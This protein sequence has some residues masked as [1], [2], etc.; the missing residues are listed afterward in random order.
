MNSESHPKTKKIM[1]AKVQSSP[2]NHTT[3]DLTESPFQAEKLNQV[4][5]VRIPHVLQTEDIQSHQAS[6][7]PSEL[8]KNQSKSSIKSSSDSIPLNPQSN[9][10]LTDK[11]ELI[12]FEINSNKQEIKNYKHNQDSFNQEISVIKK[13]IMKIELKLQDFNQKFEGLGPK[14]VKSFKNGKFSKEKSKTI[15]KQSQEFD[16][17][18]NQASQ[19]DLKTKRLVKV[20]LEMGKVSNDFV[21]IKNFIK[22]QVK[23]ISDEHV[24]FIESIN[25]LKRQIDSMVKRESLNAKSFNDKIAEVRNE[26]KEVKGPLA[27][28]ISDQTRESCSLAGEVRR[29]QEVFRSLMDD[30]NPRPASQNSRVKTSEG[31]SNRVGS[32]TPSMTSK[33]KYYRSNKTCNVASIEDNWMSLMPDGKQVWLP[34]VSYKEMINEKD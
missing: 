15:D 20:E 5:E 12:Q 13:S 22:A 18:L 14:F 11:L 4:V 17:I 9:L 33:H 21:L 26:I 1:K 19:A 27:S 34:R 30:I 8:I 31:C 3:Q 16:Q 25:Y 28:L 10:N 23:Q 29:N 6:K 24:Q 7:T 2:A 32:A